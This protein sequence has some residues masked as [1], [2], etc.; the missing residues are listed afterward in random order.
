MGIT[1][2]SSYDL[3]NKDIQKISDIILNYKKYT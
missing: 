2:P 3:K 1:L